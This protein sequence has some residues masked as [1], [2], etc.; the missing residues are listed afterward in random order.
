[1]KKII[2]DTDFL[3]HCAEAKVDYTPELRRICDFHYSTNIIDKTLDELKS[4]IEK[5]KGKH[6]R[7]AKLALLILKKKKLNRIKTK[8]DK[9]VD[10]LILEQANQNIIVATTDAN[11]KK[12]LKNKGIQVIV[13][14]QKKYL[15]MI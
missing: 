4:I 6:K 5:K 12:K 11:L 14:R 15:T 13:L 2:L 9:I 3:I 10:K 7:N 8:K 1:M